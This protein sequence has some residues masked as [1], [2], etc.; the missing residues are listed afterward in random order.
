L[1][2]GLSKSPEDQKQAG[3]AKTLAS[4]V[5]EQ[6]REMY[7]NTMEEAFVKNGIDAKVRAAGKGKERLTITYALMSQ[8]L[9]YKFQ[10]EMDVPTQAKRFGFSKVVYTNGF[11]SSL[12][13]SWTVDL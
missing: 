3:E 8:P 6:V 9:V 5:A 10:N 12:G 7:A 1:S 4:Q 2:R 13:Q 11:E